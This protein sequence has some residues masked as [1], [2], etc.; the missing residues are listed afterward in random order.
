MYEQVDA[1]PDCQSRPAGVSAAAGTSVLLT[2]SLL[3]DHSAETF[4]TLKL[5]AH[6]S[7]T[8]SLSE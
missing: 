4:L 6:Y 5:G 8:Q 7:R 3:K 2:G 1:A